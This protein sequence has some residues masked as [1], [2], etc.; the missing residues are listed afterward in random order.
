MRWQR[1]ERNERNEEPE[2][3]R[4][5][6]ADV[7]REP[8]ARTEVEAL[9][10]RYGPALFRRCRTLLGS[11]AEAQDCLQ[12]TFVGFL[13]GNWRGEAQPFTVLY[14]IATFQAID[15]LR[16]R[17]RWYG[18]AAELEVREDEPDTTVE[19]QGAAWAR[20]QDT[21]PTERVE[22]AHDL[23]ILTKG[24]DDFTMTAAMMHWVEG[25]TLEEIAQTLGV[26][27]KTVSARLTRFMERVKERRKEPT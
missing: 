22:F 25:H 1:N 5:T 20:R 15:R 6:R 19:E 7:G 4:D 3:S 12:D 2:Q 26:T 10:R 14:R 9:Y 23:A 8:D 27:R 11:D 21:S 18:K 24:E 16:R 13:K 17:G